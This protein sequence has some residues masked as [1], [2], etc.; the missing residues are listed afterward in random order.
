VVV[1]AEGEVAPFEPTARG[2][3]ATRHAIAIVNVRLIAA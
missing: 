1:A 2:G 3:S